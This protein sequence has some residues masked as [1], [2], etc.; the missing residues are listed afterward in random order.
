MRNDYSPWGAV[1]D[2]EDV[3]V[4]F[5]D[6]PSGKGWWVPAEGVLFLERTLSRA[7]ARV[8]LAHELEHI[9]RGD[10]SVADVSSVLHVRQEIAASVSA[11][12]RLIPMDRLIDALLWSQDERELAEILNVDEE[13]VKTRLLTLTPDEHVQ[14]DDRVWQAEGDIA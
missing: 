12:R 8:V 10:E 3:L 4:V 6:L 7:E 14:I 9:R 1:T 11:A 2:L 5:D 13:T